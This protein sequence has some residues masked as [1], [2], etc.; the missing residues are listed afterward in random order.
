MSFGY[1][2][3]PGVPAVVQL[4]DPEHTVGPPALDEASYFLSKIE[5]TRG[6]EPTM[7]AWPKRLFIATSYLTADA[8]EFLG[9]PRDQTV[10]MGS[11]MDV[12]PGTPRSGWCWPRSRRR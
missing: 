11:R 12:R 8:A 7:A 6:A 4:L 1:L 3:K 2:D 9:L 10:I 5:L